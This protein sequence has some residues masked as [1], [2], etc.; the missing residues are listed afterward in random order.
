M[1]YKDFVQHSR[2]DMIYNA[3]GVEGCMKQMVVFLVAGVA[4]TACPSPVNESAGSDVEICVENAH[5]SSA[6]SQFR[7]L[8]RVGNL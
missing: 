1:R 2:I 4:L 7:S 3:F 8:C 6:E 5:D